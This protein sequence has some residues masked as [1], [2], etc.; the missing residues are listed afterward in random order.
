M[1]DYFKFA[2]SLVQDDM[3]GDSGDCCGPVFHQDSEVTFSS[4][5]PMTIAKAHDEDNLCNN[6]L[7]MPEDEIIKAYN[8]ALDE[9]RF[10]DSV[11]KIRPLVTAITTRIME[12]VKLSQE[13][14]NRIRAII[15]TE[16]LINEESK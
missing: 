12:D 15:S 13:Q 11:L 10:V 6:K 9:R 16:L 3:C 14:L 2:K 1:N 4:R 7:K 8:R 5:D